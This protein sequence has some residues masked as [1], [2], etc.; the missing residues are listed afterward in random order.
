MVSH[1]AQAKRLYT[2]NKIIH[3]EEV[4]DVRSESMSVQLGQHDSTNKDEMR[5]MK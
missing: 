2:Y 4:C 5:M 3:V 1:R